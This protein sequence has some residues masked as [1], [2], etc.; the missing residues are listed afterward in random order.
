MSN[1]RLKKFLNSSDR[2]PKGI[3]VKELY[4]S[5]IFIFS[6]LSLNVLA[7]DFDEKYYEQPVREVSIIVS[8]TGFFPDQMMAFEGEK[9]KFFITS[10]SK[11]SQC[12]VLQKHELFMAAEK[13]VVNEAEVTVDHPG[14]F[15]FYCPSFG[16]E[17]WLTVFKKGEVEETRKPA[18]VEEEKPKYWLPRDYDE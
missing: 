12:M 2:K 8:D 6:I 9:I 11:K 17:G 15:R 1:I 4:F 13:G 16:H 5:V 10:T 18:N 7:I 14:K 3:I